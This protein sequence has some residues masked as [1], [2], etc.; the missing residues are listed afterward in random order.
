MVIS[1]PFHFAAKVLTLDNIETRSISLPTG[2]RR[3][4]RRDPHH[5]YRI[6]TTSG[7]S[8]SLF[9]PE[10]IV[11]AHV[12][13]DDVIVMHDVLGKYPN[14]LLFGHTRSQ[15]HRRSVNPLDHP[16]RLIAVA[17]CVR[18]NIRYRFHDAPISLFHVIFLTAGFEFRLR[19]AVAPGFPQS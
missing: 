14:G 18:Q 1:F 15:P 2:H 9:G 12:S 17:L 13:T 3:S 8:Y 11:P 6:A 10:V 4:S 19:S 16:E 7:D 5:M